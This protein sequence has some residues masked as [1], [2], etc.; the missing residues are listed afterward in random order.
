[1]T[2]T[3]F[4]VEHEDTGL[5]CYRF[6]PI[7][8]L[9]D[10]GERHSRQ[11]FRKHPSPGVDAGIERGMEKAEFCGFKD[12]EQ[13]RRWFTDEEL[14]ELGELGYKIVK[15]EDVEITVIGKKQVLF[16]KPAEKICENSE[17]LLDIVF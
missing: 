3:V 5:G 14:C 7:E 11:E 6:N 1:M 9:I 4:R 13:L 12:M 8:F 15:L 2:D 17:I 16:R 10:M